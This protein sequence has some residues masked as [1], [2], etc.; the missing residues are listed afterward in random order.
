M[1]TAVTIRDP[2]EIALNGSFI[3]TLNQELEA[4]KGA[5]RNQLEH[6]ITVGRMLHIAKSKLRHGEWKPWL[7]DKYHGSYTSAQVAMKL[8]AA[9]DSGQS[10]RSQDGEAQSIRGALAAIT[11]TRTQRNERA[12]QAL[13]NGNGH[14]GPA[15]PV[16]ELTLDQL[17]QLARKRWHRT[18]D[19]DAVL[20]W[21]QAEGIAA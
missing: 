6:A 14:D 1:A 16:Y 12:V 17:V 20:A 11:K 4:W 3:A 8:A 10:L 21:L 9:H 5:Y 15:E 19:A 7:A 13:G 2:D 18:P